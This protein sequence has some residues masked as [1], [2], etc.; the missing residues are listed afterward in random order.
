M[1]LTPTRTLHEKGLVSS[2][3]TQK[4]AIYAPLLTPFPTDCRLYLNYSVT[5]LSA[6]ALQRPCPPPSVRRLSEKARLCTSNCQCCTAH[7]CRRAAHSALARFCL[8]SVLLAAAAAADIA[9]E[10]RGALSAIVS[11]PTAI[12]MIVITCTASACSS[13]LKVLNEEIVLPVVDATKRDLVKGGKCPSSEFVPERERERLRS[14][15]ASKI[16]SALAEYCAN[17]PK[18]AADIITGVAC[19][20]FSLRCFLFIASLPLTQLEQSS[21]LPTFPPGYKWGRPCTPTYALQQ[22]TLLAI[23][24]SRK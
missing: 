12:L 14:D 6:L 19:F 13:G 11:C 17:V 3:H 23:L 24:R 10:I 7:S 1:L 16:S 15:A 18:S 20:R 5:A 9:N 2:C 22:P 21:S 8:P 4:P